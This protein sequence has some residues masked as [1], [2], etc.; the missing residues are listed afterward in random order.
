MWGIVCKIKIE[1]DGINSYIQLT[2]TLLLNMSLSPHQWS[3][4][5]L[6]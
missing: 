6:L 5:T 1:N 2:N 4:A 3:R